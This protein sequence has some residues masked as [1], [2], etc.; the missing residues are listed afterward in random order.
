LAREFADD[1][2]TTSQTPTTQPTTTTTSPYA[3]PS[4]D[5]NI[6]GLTRELMASQA[7]GVAMSE[8][9][10]RCVAA[11]MLTKLGLDPLARLGAQAGASGGQLD[12]NTLS[13]PEREGFAD[14]LIGCIDLN[15]LMVD[16]L[17]PAL[18][19]PQASLGCVA[20][21]LAEDGTLTKVLRQVVVSGADPSGADAALTS[22]M[23]TAL[24]NCL[25]PEQLQTLTVPR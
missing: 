19:L 23:L 20:Q 10:A 17:G 3:Q 9:Q 6:E 15:Q 8:T 7:G 24:D 2:P 13:A 14:A 11:G 21:R 1:G 25:S 12:L 22:P 18:G 4:A 5:P 16:Q